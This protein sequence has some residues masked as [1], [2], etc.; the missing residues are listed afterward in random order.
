[1]F[2]PT[3]RTM[4]DTLMGGGGLACNFGAAA[5]MLWGRGWLGC[6]PEGAFNRPQ[7]TGGAAM[8]PRAR[9]DH[10]LHE[11]PGGWGRSRQRTAPRLFAWLL[12]V[13]VV[14]VLAIGLHVLYY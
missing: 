3:Q 8:L 10:D 2:R 11:H 4:A 13:A 12:A 9:D 6:P 7:R 14:A 5:S 1:L